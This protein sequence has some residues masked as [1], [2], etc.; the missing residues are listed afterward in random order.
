[1]R[2]YKLL[3]LL[4]ISLVTFSCSGWLDVK[5]Q[6]E[7]DEKD[8]FASGDGYRH[9]LNG[10]Y[11]GMSDKSLYGQELTWGIVDALA[12]CYNFDET[13][14]ETTGQMAK[15]GATGYLWDNY[16]LKPAIERMW[17]NTYKIVANCNNLIQNIENEDPEKFYY[18]EAEKRM[19]WGEALAVRAAIQLDMVRLFAASPAMDAK[20]KNKVYIPYVSEYPSYVSK[21][22]TADS[23]LSHVIRDLEDARGLL[24]K[25]DSGVSFSSDSRF[26]K[27]VTGVKLF[28]EGKRGFRLNYYATT[29]IL[30]RACL[31][32]QKTEKAY[33]YAKEIID[34]QNETNAFRYRNQTS[35]GDKKFYSD[36]IWGLE[37]L[38]LIEYI[39]AINRLTNPDPWYQYY[40][41]VLNVKESFFQDDIVDKE[42][43]DLRFKYWMYDLGAGTNFRFTKYEKYDSEETKAK[44]SN[45]MIPMVRMSEVYYIAAE[46]IYEKNLSEAKGYVRK[47][48]S[49]RGLQSGDASM[50]NLDRVDESNFMD[51]LIND[52]RREWLGEGQI[53]FMY[54]RLNKT[55]P[56]AKLG[57][58]IPADAE[59]MIVP[60]PD[61][62]TNLN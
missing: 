24:W 20:D 53:F 51:V 50:I 28:F 34:Y 19:I 29:A 1:M 8:L 22:L 43:N 59:H 4:L 58:F 49:G 48:K 12:Q 52:A 35:S 38:D 41:Q 17:E 26:E 16:Q 44:I 39:N 62:E 61:T 3:F 2:K 27:N 46:A 54:K 31:Y 11:Y 32:A 42:C 30:A 57:D 55:I 10:I 9:L 25:A 18:K 14:S 45:Y 6:D 21:R 56:A 60:V 47:V 37:S 7:I 33:T 23:C 5:P 36:I 13:T 40:L 15:Y